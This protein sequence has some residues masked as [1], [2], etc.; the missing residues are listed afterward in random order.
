V[1]R[2]SKAERPFVVAVAVADELNDELTI[3]L[4]SVAESLATLD[5]N[6]PAR[7]LLADVKHSAERCVWRTNGLLEYGRRRGI[8]SHGSTPFVNLLVD[9]LPPVR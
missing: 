3:I 1:D 6:H 5:F 4:N 2:F 8:V 9:D 7:E